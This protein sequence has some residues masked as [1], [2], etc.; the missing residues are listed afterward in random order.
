MKTEWRCLRCGKF[1]HGPQP[2][3]RHIDRIKGLPCTGAWKELGPDLT[4]RFVADTI[5]L[6]LGNRRLNEDS[7]CE[8]VEKR[9]EERFPH[10]YGMTSD[11]FP[12]AVLAW[13]VL[14]ARE[15]EWS[16]D[17]KEECIEPLIY[18]IVGRGWARHRYLTKKPQVLKEKEKKCRTSSSSP[19]SD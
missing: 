1:E 10:G 11:V 7:L 9:F 15:L 4:R 12:R 3:K 16:G 6:V 18:R 13:M 2:P 17:E 19:T 14:D 8:R 5:L